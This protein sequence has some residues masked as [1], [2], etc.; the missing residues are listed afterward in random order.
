MNIENL[1]FITPVS[2]PENLLEI[3]VHLSALQKKH[4]EVQITWWTVFDSFICNASPAW[5]EYAKTLSFKV[6]IENIG[7]EKGFGGR[8]RSWAISKIQF[9]WMHFLDDDTLPHPEIVNVANEALEDES[10]SVIVWDQ[11]R[12]KNRK[13]GVTIFPCKPSNVRFCHI[14]MGSFLVLRPLLGEVQYFKEGDHKLNFM[15]NGFGEDYRFIAKLWDKHYKRFSFI[16]KAASYY[17]WLKD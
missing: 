7:L 17:N 16:S 13:E 1:H 8:Q 15:D 14:D 3:S 6:E 5:I 9:G 10:T 11:L 4:P 12:D 2:R